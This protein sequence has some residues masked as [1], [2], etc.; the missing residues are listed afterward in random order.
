MLKL[1]FA[2]VLLFHSAVALSQSL[3]LQVAL[4]RALSQNLLLKR[5][6]ALQ[7][8]VEARTLITLS[9]EKPVVSF[10]I[11]GYA[12]LADRKSDC[13]ALADFARV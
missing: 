7:A 12:E 4:E 11:G 2:F 8:S 13:S 1:I 9:P 5:Q 6:V 10:Y 3:S